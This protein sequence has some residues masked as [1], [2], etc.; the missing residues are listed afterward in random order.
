MIIDFYAHCTL[1]FSNC[2]FN[3][4]VGSD[5][6]RLPALKFVESVVILYT[7]DPNGSMELPPD[8]FSEGK[9]VLCICGNLRCK[10]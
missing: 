7:P 2:Q 4:K 5:G 9:C 3:Y 8:Q 10:K 1:A 6:R